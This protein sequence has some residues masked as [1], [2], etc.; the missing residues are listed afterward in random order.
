MGSYE[1]NQTLTYN[2]FS[3]EPEEDRWSRVQ[4]MH[5][6]RLGVGVAVVNR[7]LYAIGGFDGHS[8]LASI[9]CYH[10]ENNAWSILPP[11]KTGRSG[12]G[13]AALNQYIY[14]VGG[15][16]GRFQV[17]SCERYD[18]EQQIWDSVASIQIARSA[19]S[20]TVLDGKLYA[21]G[22]FDGHSFLNIVEVYDPSNDRWEEGTPLTSGRSGHAS[23]VIYQPSCASV[24]MDCIGEPTDKSKQQPEDDENTGNGPSTS[25]NIPA[26]SIPTNALHSFSG[27]RCNHCDDNQ[28]SD[29]GSNNLNM[30]SI[31]GENHAE[32][33]YRQKESESDQSA[34]ETDVFDS[35]NNGNSNDSFATDNIENEPQKRRK[36]QKKHHCPLSK[37]TSA[38]RQ[39]INDFVTW[40]SSS[41]APSTSTS[42]ITDST[43]YHKWSSEADP[44]ERITTC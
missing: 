34:D 38:F 43:S 26:P 25:K 31:E 3:Y 44:D 2:I 24:Y 36:L 39:N 4:S 41:T 13:V 23:A 20:L 9:E 29:Y 12:A 37:L 10:P 5:S 14:V 28:Q 15:F 40:S 21:M 32:K 18:T 8:R 19:L 22:G 17:S 7:L 35:D 30:S 42:S 1:Y 16:D 33:E 6:K 11:M 27:N